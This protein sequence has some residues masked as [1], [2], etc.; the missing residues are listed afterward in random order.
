MS[1]PLDALQL[2]EETEVPVNNNPLVTGGGSGTSD[3]VTQPRRED[4]DHPP[5][6]FDT[7]ASLLALTRK[8]NVRRLIFYFKHLFDF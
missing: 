4:D 6:P 3:S 8:H 7:G 5:Y 1:E 2:A